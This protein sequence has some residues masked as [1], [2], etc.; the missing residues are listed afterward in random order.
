MALRALFVKFRASRF[1]LRASHKLAP[2]QPRPSSAQRKLHV[3][4][5]ATPRSRGQCFMRAA[6]AAPCFLRSFVAF[7]ERRSWSC[8]RMMVPAHNWSYAM[9]GQLTRLHPTWGSRSDADNAVPRL[10]TSGCGGRGMQPTAA[11]PWRSVDPIQAPDS[12]PTIPPHFPSPRLIT[13]RVH[14]PL[15]SPQAHTHTRIRSVLIEVQPRL[16]WPRLT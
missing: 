13:L 12:A 5:H 14:I 1:V 4:R 11:A 3:E 10:S 8:P 7:G 15:T 2:P 16:A 6:N 9:P